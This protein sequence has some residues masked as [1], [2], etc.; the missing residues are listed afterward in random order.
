VEDIKAYIESGVLELYVLG[1]VTPGERLQVEEMALQHPAIKAELDEIE[2]S[3]E[4][5]A[6][7]NAVE[8]AEDL[9][10]RIMNSMVTNL[11]DDSIF[12]TKKTEPVANNVIAL[13]AMKTN[14][15]YKY[16]FAACLALLL[17]SS[18]AL[19]NMYNRLQ[20]STTQLAALQLDKQQFASRVNLVNQQ[21]EVFRD[22]SFK[23]L[24]LQATPK[25]PPGA[26]VTIAWSPAKHKV[27]I[28]MS[29]MKMPVNDKDHQYQLW[30]IVAGKPVDLGVF[31]E[32]PDANNMK[33]MKTMAAISADAFAVTLEPRGGSASPTMD[34]MMVLGKF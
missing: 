15:F 13:S 27:M 17:A 14:G 16:A 26:A 20:Q 10:N 9:R 3:I 32:T 34:E 25:A 33:E 29:S 8:P 21:L 19:L 23:F 31:D 4:L 7:E 6:R 24:K 28:D 1:D 11:G 18:I 5:Y 2:R 12:K 22:A 30:A